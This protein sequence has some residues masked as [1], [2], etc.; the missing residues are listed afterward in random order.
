MDI[1]DDDDGDDDDDEDD[2]DDDGDCDGD[3]D[4]DCDGGDDDLEANCV[5][6]IRINGRNYTDVLFLC[7]YCEFAEKNVAPAC[8][9]PWLL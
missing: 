3:D 5:H 4:G 6:C 2:S 8:L 1:N 9:P 7:T